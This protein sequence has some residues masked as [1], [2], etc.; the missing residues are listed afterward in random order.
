MQLIPNFLEPKIFKKIKETVFSNQ[1]P[2]YYSDQTG[3]LSDDSDFMFSHKFFSD[4]N[5]QD[6]QEFFSFLI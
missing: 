4:N 1:F 6:S 2:F 3:S 5:Q